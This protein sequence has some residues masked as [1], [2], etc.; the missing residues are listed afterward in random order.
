MD[1]MKELMRKLTAEYGLEGLSEAA[2]LKNDWSEIVGPSL[3]SKT[4]PIRI[5]GEVLLLSCAGPAWSHQMNMMQSVICEKLADR[6]FGVKKIRTILSE[7][8]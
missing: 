5:S 8:S 7:E 6:G 2:E 3:A 4:K 1:S